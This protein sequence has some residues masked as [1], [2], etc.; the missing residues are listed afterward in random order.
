MITD[1]IAVANTYRNNLKQAEYLY[2]EPVTLFTL[3]KDSI[4]FSRIPE[5]LRERYQCATEIAQ[6]N[7]KKY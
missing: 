2:N 1:T 5:M 4:Y 7:F 6:N 3:V